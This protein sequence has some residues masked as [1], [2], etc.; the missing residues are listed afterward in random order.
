MR[1]QLRPDGRHPCMRFQTKL[2]LCVRE[3]VENLNIISSVFHLSEDE[4]CERA[5]VLT[6][7]FSSHL[8]APLNKMLSMHSQN[9]RT[10]HPHLSCFSCKWICAAHMRNRAADRILA[11]SARSSKQQHMYAFVNDLK[12]YSSPQLLFICAS[13]CLWVCVCVCV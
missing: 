6:I 7:S 5:S 3:H 4:L 10:M 12:I 13:V 1:A 11:R 2:Y 9:G 8:H